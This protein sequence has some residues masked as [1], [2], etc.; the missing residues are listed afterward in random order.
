[1]LRGLWPHL[2][3][4][5]KYLYGSAAL[6]LVMAVFGLVRP[7]VMKAALE[8][9]QQPEGAAMLT[10]FGLLIGGLILVEQV[11][12]FPQLYWLQLAGARA[13]A[14]LRRRVFTFLHTR[15][16]AFFDRTPL[17]RLVTRVTNDVDAIAE[18]FA[19]GA[20]NAIGDLIRLVAIVA[21]MLSL[22]WQMSLF[23]FAVLPPVV[24]A[25][26]WTRKRMRT[27][28][29]EIRTKTARM[30]AF[31]NEQVSGI[32]I[33][34]AYAR[35]SRSEGEFDAI[36]YAY[37][38]ANTR[39]IVLDASLDATI[40]MVGSMCIAAV[41]W[42][43]GVRAIS[44]DITFGTLFAFVA[45]LEMFFMPVR[46]L[47]ARYTAIQSAL[48]GSERVF[49][50]LE[51]AD[52]DAEVRS[53]AQGEDGAVEDWPREG[54]S[55]FA[56]H[57]VTFGYKPGVP[58]VHD[59]HLEARRGETVAL[60]GP[61][62]SG[63]S[64]I[65]S[66]LLRLYEVADGEGTVEVLGRDVRTIGRNALRSQFA[67]VPQDVF[68][69]PGTV[70][71]NIAARDAEPDMDKVRATLER[72][73]ALDLFESR[74]G[75]LDAKVIER[76]TNF[77]AGERQLMAFARALYRNPPLLILDE[78]TANIDSDT[79]S[80][81]QRAMDVALEGRTALVI[82]H[83]LS[84][85]RNANRL[86]VMHQGRI[87]EQGTHDEL[88]ELDGIYARLHRL[89]VAQQAIEERMDELVEPVSA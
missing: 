82:A 27:A 8:R 36:N 76:G 71:S 14:D 45:Y 53:G 41:L 68:L 30:N 37:R 78:P 26:N 85:V 84:T 3:P 23:A 19:M 44:E 73:G 38:A 86:V 51:S 55:A 28:Y 77:S 22:D 34:Q 72:I 89:Q 69:F 25:V 1:M 64:T 57:D 74:E 58:V 67:V 35:E 21:I 81:L 9:F 79:E 49:Q 24:L 18:M 10:Q 42:Y 56:L 66:L 12:S 2:H 6:L 31:L 33:V 7:L 65:A 59:M 63:K 61:T 80:R 13:M 60:V 54:A 17:G 5:R 83:R 87:V 32:E 47:S 43:A 88:V 20:L 75:G 40:E 29:R 52:E 46:H 4:H 50:L 16:M 15:S 70:A 11:L 62:G 39:A 48:A